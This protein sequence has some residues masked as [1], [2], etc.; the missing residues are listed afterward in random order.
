MLPSALPAP[1]HRAFIPEVLMDYPIPSALD[2]HRIFNQLLIRRANRSAQLFQSPMEDLAPLGAEQSIYFYEPFAGLLVLRTSE[3]FDRFLQDEAL[4]SLL[5]LTVLFYHQLFKNAWNLDTRKTKPAL[6][7]RSI[8]LDWPDRRFN[9][10]C[11][12]FVKD[13]PVEIRL[14]APV[15]EPEIEKWRRARR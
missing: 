15:S 6:F 8:P 2:L 4:G 5:E 11:T 12:L 10:G 1:S 9:S 13:F 14:W 7:K 3:D